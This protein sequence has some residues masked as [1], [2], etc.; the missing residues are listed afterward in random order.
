MAGR[1]TTSVH[2]RAIVQWPPIKVE[3]VHGAHARSKL[4]RDLGE[5]TVTKGLALA[6]AVMWQKCF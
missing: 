1:D 6:S 3:L 5:N 2:S 4:R